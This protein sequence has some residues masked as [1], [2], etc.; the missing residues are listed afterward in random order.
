MKDSTIDATHSYWGIYHNG[1]YG[2][3][4]SQVIGSY[5]YADGATGQG[6]YI[7]ANRSLAENTLTI[8]DSEIYGE[9]GVEV[10]FTKSSFDTNPYAARAEPARADSFP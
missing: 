8:K 1:S 4:D 6:I 3:A 5:V 7:A 2:G 10:K 9:T